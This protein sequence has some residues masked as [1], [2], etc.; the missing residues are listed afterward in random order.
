MAHVD[1][2][3][4]LLVAT[5]A[6]TR[7]AALETGNAAPSAQW[8]A[9]A[10]LR[11][12]GPLRVGELAA[13]GRVTQ[14][15]MTRLV[16][17]MDDAGLVERT[18]DDADSRATVVTATQHGVDAYLAWRTQ[19]AETLLPRFADLDDADWDALRTA[20][21]ILSARIGSTASGANTTASTTAA[22]A[23]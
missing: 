13:L 10:I 16:G 19:L 20:A 12:N 23:R 21:R 3:E 22:A 5:H 9:I 6:L 7:V 18:T 4:Q 1:D 2:L 15:S 8:R 14:P 11:E 17:I